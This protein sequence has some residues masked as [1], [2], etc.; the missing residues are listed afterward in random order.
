MIAF[1]DC[2]S[3]I[4]G[5]MTLGAF[6]DIGVPAEWLKESIYNIPLHDFDLSVSSVSRN[7][8]AAKRV[9]V[10]TS[11]SA[12]ARNYSQILELISKSRL[13]EKV[14]EKSISVFEIIADAE[15]EIHGCPREK[16]HFH[17][18]GGV[19]AIVDIVGAALCIEYLGI[20][21]ISASKIP[22]TSGFVNCR[23]GKIPVPAPATVSILKGVPVYGMDINNELVTPTGAAILKA[24]SESFGIFPDMTVDKS[25]YGAGKHVIEQIP[26]LLRI[27]TGRYDENREY[28]K[29]SILQIETSI[30]D[31]NPEIF[32]FLM[33]RLFEDGA[34]DVYWIPVFMKKNRPGTEVRVI[35]HHD[36][37][38]V[39]IKR[40]LSET[41]T[42]GVRCHDA[43]RTLLSRKGVEI[44]TRYGSVTVKCITSPDG[45]TR[46]VPEYEVCKKIALSKNLPLKVVYENIVKDIGV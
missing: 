17:E 32:G 40:I 6:I 13:S 7:G 1:F 34:L 19:D 15:A 5:D 12:A 43:E 23:H 36:K 25:G 16:V 4:S 26:N 42:I 27:V 33:E 35:C 18:L 39:I 14:K 3:G 24:F 41:T 21:K 38:D 46:F 30:D 10:K 29:E 11:D 45:S 8:I 2:F 37:K 9:E 22:M 31:M 20:T 44:N 28:S